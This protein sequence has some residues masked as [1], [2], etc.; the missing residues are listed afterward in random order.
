MLAKGTENAI[1]ALVYIHL[2]NLKSL[3]PG[4]TEIAREVD[5]PEAY[6]GKIL[7]TLTKH[8]LLN[9]QKGRGGGFFFDDYQSNLRILDVIVVMEGDSY[10]HKCGIGLKDCNDKNPCPL[11]YEY[12]NVRDKFHEIVRNETI[13]SLAEKILKGKAVINRI[14][15]T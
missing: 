1:R 4:V 15:K 2:R 13:K 6:L 3:R 7:Q 8:K 5:A 14:V 11:H 10:F 12:I 9:S